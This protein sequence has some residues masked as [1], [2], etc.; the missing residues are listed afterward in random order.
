MVT[1]RAADGTV[2]AV[3]VACPSFAV[4]VQWH[5]EEDD[6]D[7]RLFAALVTAGQQYAAAQ[8]RRRRA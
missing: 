1:G 2:E 7:A 6:E 8:D 5:P 4:G 3:E